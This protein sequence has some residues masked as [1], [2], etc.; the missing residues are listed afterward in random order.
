[1]DNRVV[2]TEDN[3]CKTL[4]VAYQDWIQALRLCRSA[5]VVSIRVDPETNH[6]F[7]LTGCRT[8]IRA[9]FGDQECRDSEIRGT[10]RKVLT[11][12]KVFGFLFLKRTPVFGFKWF[13]RNSNRVTSVPSV[14]WRC[15]LGG[16]KGTRPVKVSGGVL[17]WLSVWNEVQTCIIIIIIKGIYIAQGRKGQNCAMSAEMA[18]W[19]RNCLYL[20]SYL[21][22]N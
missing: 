5:P 10:K 19:L 4:P 3:T 16:R 18:V 17:T 11:F 6:N 12:F 13:C 21:S 9:Y 14:L 2:H 7:D 8:S 20:Y 1:V 22:H 15:W